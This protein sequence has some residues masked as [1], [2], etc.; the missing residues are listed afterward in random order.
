MKKEHGQV[1]GFIWRGPDVL[2]AY[3][4][5]RVYAEQHHLTESADAKLHV[6]SAL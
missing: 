4:Q 5:L 3:L 2:A 1:T 6:E